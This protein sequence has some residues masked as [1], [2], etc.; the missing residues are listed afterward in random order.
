MNKL[1]LMSA[2]VIAAAAFGV[3]P[4]FAQTSSGSGMTCYS[5]STGKQVPCPGPRRS[6]PPVYTPPSTTTP[7]NNAQI[8]ADKRAAEEAQRRRDEAARAAAAEAERQR[9]ERE[10]QEEFERSKQDGINSLKGNT[11]GE[12]TLKGGSGSDLKLKDGSSSELKLK[13]GAT[14]YNRV[15]KPTAVTSVRG[16]D[17]A[18]YSEIP[19]DL[20]GLGRLAEKLGW[21][22]E[23]LKRFAEAA[24]DLTDFDIKHTRE[25]R[26]DMWARIKARNT[27]GLQRAAA[28]EKG[29]GLPSSGFQTGRYADCVIFAISNASG[30]PYGIASTRAMEL[31]SSE[32]WRLSYERKDPQGEILKVV[33]G[34]R[35]GMTGNEML[36]LAEAFGQAQ[37]VR[38]KDFA[39]T[40]KV[41]RP[42]LV[43]VGAGHQ[44]ILSK[45]FQYKG[46][47]WFEM[48]DSQ[49]KGPWQRRYVKPGE[50][51]VLLLENGVA[52]RPEKGETIKSLK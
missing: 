30:V 44:V 1:A 46:E 26:K 9:V 34:E 25:E 21:S 41:G 49:A 5:R 42:V 37:V 6:Q 23:E 36:Y 39:S 4:A 31:L 22:D 24:R 32:E 28:L 43:N 38:P 18:D 52:Y 14:D 48:V 12:P 7:N 11:S 35:R 16:F 50:L 8:E 10:R 3:D 19:Y 40:L 45:V 47:T 20:D 17:D 15:R 13:D 33:P 51:D 2:M 29:A 27:L